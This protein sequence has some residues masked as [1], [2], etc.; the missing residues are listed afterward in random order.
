MVW[1]LLSS[2]FLLISKLT[3]ASLPPYPNSN[4]FYDVYT[5]VFTMRDGSELGV[6]ESRAVDAMQGSVQRLLAVDTN[7]DLLDTARSLPDE[8]L[9]R[10]LFLAVAGNFTT[11]QS[12]SALPQTCA[13]VVDPVSGGFVLK[14]VGSTQ[15]VILEI[16]LI[17]S[18]VCLLKAWKG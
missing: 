2:L 8:A 10:I 4:L 11:Y 5:D 7:T 1:L 15:S 18:I 16:L 13:L 14:D 3:A 12:P 6:S 9:L 17:I